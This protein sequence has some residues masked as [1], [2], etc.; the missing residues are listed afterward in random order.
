MRQEYVLIDMEDGN[1]LIYGCN[2]RK[3]QSIAREFNKDL[4]PRKYK[5]I[6][7]QNYKQVK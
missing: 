4:S 3:L 2:F 7:V 6:M 5:V 1:A